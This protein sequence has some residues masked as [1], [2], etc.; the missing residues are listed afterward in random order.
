MILF[1]QF[2]YSFICAKRDPY[3]LDKILLAVVFPEA[4]EPV[5]PIFF[6]S[7]LKVI[8][9]LIFHQFRD[10]FYSKDKKTFVLGK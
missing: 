6:I 7:I 2:F 1:I 4:M 8:I 9:R 10:L 5:T 3:F